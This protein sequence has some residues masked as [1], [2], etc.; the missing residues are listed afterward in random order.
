MSLPAVRQRQ[1]EKR[2][3]EESSKVKERKRKREKYAEKVQLLLEDVQLCEFP[4]NR[5]VHLRSST[6]HTFYL[7][8]LSLSEGHLRISIFI[9]KSKKVPETDFISPLRTMIIQRGSRNH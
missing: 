5:G 3:Q 2:Q 1:E 4:E 6:A 8:S 9:L 7:G